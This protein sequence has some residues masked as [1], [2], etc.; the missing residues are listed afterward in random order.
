MRLSTPVPDVEPCIAEALQR[1]DT[2]QHDVTRW[3]ANWLDSVMRGA[4]WTDGQRRTLAQLCER[5]LAD[6]GTRLA[7]EIRGQQRLL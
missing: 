2:M 5:Y 7:A 4:F 3:E 6:D 1:I